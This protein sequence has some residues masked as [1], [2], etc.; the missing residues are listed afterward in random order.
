MTAPRLLSGGHGGRRQCTSTCHTGNES[1]NLFRLS[2]RKHLPGGPI[3]RAGGRRRGNSPV[4][5]VT[6]ES[7]LPALL[8]SPSAFSSSA[9][10]EMGEEGP[11]WEGGGVASG[12]SSILFL[13]SKRK[14]SR[15]K[16]FILVAAPTLW[17]RDS[18]RNQLRGNRRRK[19]GHEHNVRYRAGAGPSRGNPGTAGAPGAQAARNGCASWL[20]HGEK[21]DRAGV[22]SI[23]PRL[24]SRPSSPRHPPLPP[25]SHHRLTLVQPLTPARAGTSPS[26]PPASRAPAHGER[27]LHD[28]AACPPAGG[29]AGARAGAPRGHKGAGGGERRRPRWRA[30]ARK[31]TRREPSWEDADRTERRGAGS[32]APRH[33]RE[34]PPRPLL[35]LRLS[36]SGTHRPAGSGRCDQGWRGTNNNFWRGRREPGRAFPMKPE[37]A[38]E[39]VVMTQHAA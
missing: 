29:R 3:Q 32:E 20:G 27:R 18:E 6:S 34:R 9:L 31:L 5:S 16:R 15:L 30:P 28:G 1:C 7:G 22:C 10:R 19:R 39:R 26:H 37:Q 8:T 17:A 24:L 4:F 25:P 14:R 12:A 33:L 23:S 11:G 35:A 38:C 13:F 2:S 36:P 21:G